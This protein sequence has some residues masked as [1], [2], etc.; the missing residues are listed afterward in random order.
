[1]ALQNYLDT[2]STTGAAS[3]SAGA[4]PTGLDRR[5]ATDGYYIGN[6]P[7]PFLGGLTPIQFSNVMMKRFYAT[8]ILAKTTQAGS[9]KSLAGGHLGMSIVVPRTPEIKIRR[10]KVGHPRPLE[11]STAKPLT[12]EIKYGTEWGHFTPDVDQYF[13]QVRDI[14][15]Q[16][17]KGAVAKNAAVIE[18]HCFT[19][20]PDFV[21][22]YN[23]GNSAGK[24]GGNYTLGT[25][26]SPAVITRS[27]IEDYLGQFLHVIQETEVGMESGQF[28]VVIPTKMAYLLRTS[29]YMKDASV[30]GSRSSL[31]TRQLPTIFDYDIYSSN[32]LAHAT[33]YSDVWPVYAY[34][35]EALAFAMAVNKVNTKEPDRVDGIEVYGQSIYGFDCE[36]EDG[37]A[38]GYVKF[39]DTAIDTGS[40][41]ATDA[42]SRTQYDFNSN[43]ETYL[44]VTEVPAADVA[45]ANAASQTA[46]ALG[47]YVFD[48]GT[49]QYKIPTSDSA[50]ST[51]T[52]YYKEAN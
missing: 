50:V 48:S 34:T 35:K 42:D 46:K 6:Q 10:L 5:T 8:N 17:A 9:F 32:L 49:D 19:L 12:L 27:N 43:G 51:D 7:D 22:S 26:A 41:S 16:I 13:S 4:F 21:P 33:G 38:I 31:A 39:S 1:M 2:L 30:R 3:R 23:A 24:V 29:D 47:W 14:S 28:T 25:P 20:F 52:T 18:R 36:R 15:Q 45:A 37:V 44:N 11:T 40:G